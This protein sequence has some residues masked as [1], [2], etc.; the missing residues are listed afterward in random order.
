MA[1]KVGRPPKWESP[2]EL[3]TL[4]DKYFEL[5]E[6]KDEL[7]FI[8]EMCVYL[9]TS[10]KVLLEYENK[11]E[12]SNAIKRAKAKCEAAIEKNMLTNKFNATAS[13]FNLKN[14]YGW[15]ERT[16]VDNTHSVDEET[17]NSISSALDDV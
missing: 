7:P 14:N 1:N 13:I 6:A 10:R 11:K 16:K 15:E 5:C 2:E 12:F 8:T 17:R 9:D 3:Q 4:I